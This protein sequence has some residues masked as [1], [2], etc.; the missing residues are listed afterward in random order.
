MTTRRLSAVMAPVLGLVLTAGLLAACANGS[1]ETN[2]EAQRQ[3]TT[4]SPGEDWVP[5]PAR[6]RDPYVR[7]AKTLRADGVQVWFE[8]DLVQA[9]LSGPASFHAMTRRLAW[10]DR[11]VPVAGF[12][13]ADELGYQD[14]IRTAA[15]GRAFLAAV[16]RALG[17]AA[18]G[19]PVLVDVTVPDLG[20]LPWRGGRGLACARKAR[21]DYPAADDHAVSSYLHSGLIDR[22]DLSTSLL[23]DSYYAGWHV[24]RDEAQREAWMH[25]IAA[26][27]DQLAI[28]QGR[29]ALAAD[30]GYQGDARQAAADLSTYVDVP[31]AHGAHAVDIWTWRQPYDGGEASLLADG[32]QPNPLWTGL[33]RRRAAGDVLFTHMTPSAMPAEPHA[34][35]RE[36]AVAAQ[37]FDAVFVA[38]GTG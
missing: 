6:S 35:A 18:P 1:S 13:V 22:L 30:G 23:D 29:K 2:A 38:A 3:A 21:R 11:Q 25:V 37:V 26:G 7:L 12:K 15:E 28:L 31:L 24:S 14:G 4:I 33:E 5:V 34:F 9:W 19:R 32:L 17:R 8:A 27:W 20:C 10:L 16:R 36:C